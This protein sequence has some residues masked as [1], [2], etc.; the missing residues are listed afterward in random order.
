MKVG[1]EDYSYSK[2]R[3]CGLIFLNP[4]PLPKQIPGF[5]PQDYSPHQA[6]LRKKAP[7]W[8]NRLF[9]EWL[10]SLESVSK[11]PLIRAFFRLIS[12]LITQDIFE[13]RG[14]N[15]ILEIGCG[16][17]T[18]LKRHQDFG[19]TAKGVEINKKA[20]K[21]CRA[22]GL[23]VYHGKIQDEPFAGEKFDI[24]VLRHVIEH[25]LEPVETLHA[26]SKYLAPE[27]RI[28][29]TTPNSYS[30][31]FSAYG[32]YWYQLD[33]PRHIFLFSPKNL[34]ILCDK[35]G[36]RIESIKT[37]YSSRIWSESRYLFRNRN[38][39]FKQDKIGGQK[40]VSEL[41]EREKHKYRVF[42]KFI[43]PLCFISAKLGRGENLR[44]VLKL[45]E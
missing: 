26:A 30:L 3:A 20:Y 28:V 1:R 22:M 32:T 34:R 43:S 40:P 17:G 24:I 11:P 21:T 31:S 35:A 23:E 12:G 36:L 9:S 44:A 16:S 5:Y 27:G 42:R 33:A 39:A 4:L 10:Y 18:F 41:S 7:K 37:E 38:G 15:R 2:C 45:K 19:W 14:T 6:Q 8:I 13:P 25:L 29:L